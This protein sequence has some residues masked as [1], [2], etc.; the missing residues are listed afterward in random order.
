M[1]DQDGRQ[2]KA[3][4]KEQARREREELQGRM[5]AR[6][7]QRGVGVVAGLV[8][9]AALI[10]VVVL[11]SGGD[12]GGSPDDS[13]LAGMLTTP[14]PWP[15]NAAE[16]TDRLAE[17]GLPP[18]G[19]ASHIHVPLYL[20]VRGDAATVPADIGLTSTTHAPLHTHD[21][22]GTLHVESADP[23][24]V[25]NLGEFFDVWGVRLSAG[26]LGSYCTAG[27][28]ALRIFVDGA[29]V[30]TDP[31][32]IPLEEEAAIVVTFGTLDQVPDPLPSGFAAPPT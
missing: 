6:R 30:T 14:G 19:E 8:A 11:T 3:E 26:C 24:R 12:D 10:A 21:S 20:F 15:A 25:F 13:G 31:R 22:E 28:E 5:Q 29:E 1:S 27:D 18:A 17:L 4:R 16:L 2:T 7:R 9:V 32:A 23:T